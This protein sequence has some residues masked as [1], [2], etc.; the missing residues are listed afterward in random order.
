MSPCS[1]SVV[2]QRHLTASAMIFNLKKF[3]KCNVDPVWFESYFSNITQSV[4]LYDIVS[5]K[6]II[7]YGVPQGSVLGSILFNIYVNDLVSFLPNC[8]VIQDADDTQITLSSN[9]NNLKYFIQKA[10]DTVKLAKIYFNAN[11]L[12]LNPPQKKPMYLYWNQKA[13]ITYSS[14][15][16]PNG[17]WQC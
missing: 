1:L 5:E 2:C 15:H 10:E 11:V 7:S 9:N 12:M 13:F 16:T 14:Q 4:Q 17:G 3:L 6:P 8:D